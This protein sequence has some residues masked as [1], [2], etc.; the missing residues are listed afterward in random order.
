MKINLHHKITSKNIK[1]F[2]SIGIFKVCGTADLTA[3]DTK[4]NS[5]HVSISGIPSYKQGLMKK[6]SVAET[7]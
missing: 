4:K 5:E 1:N 6:P 7:M 3:T 2:P